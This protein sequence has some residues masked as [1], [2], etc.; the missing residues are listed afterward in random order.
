MPYSSANPP[1]NNLWGVGYTIQ[2]TPFDVSGFADAAPEKNRVFKIL[3]EQKINPVSGR[4]VGYKLVPQPSQL[5]LAHPE[6]TAFARA[7]FAQH[8]IW[9]VRP[10]LSRCGFP[11]DGL[12]V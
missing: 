6:S 2:K 11:T 5:L 3:N 8:H 10:T 7:E 4:A 1:A 9:F 12:H